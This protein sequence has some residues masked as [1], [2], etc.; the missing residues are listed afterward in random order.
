MPLLLL[1]LALGAYAQAPNN[2]ALHMLEGAF[3]K[4]ACSTC[5]KKARIGIMID[6]YCPVTL[7]EKRT[8][9]SGQSQFRG[10]FWGKQYYFADS[11]SLARFKADPKR[12]VIGIELR[13]RTLHLSPKLGGH[14]PVALVADDTLRKGSPDHQAF[15]AGQLFYCNSAE[16]RTRLLANR[17]IAAKAITKYTA[18]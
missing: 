11:A 9:A 16:A 6:G 17:E 18:K 4:A 5:A 10:I 7:T 14:C 12:Y 2:H 8:L 13:Y 15:L 3:S 1:F